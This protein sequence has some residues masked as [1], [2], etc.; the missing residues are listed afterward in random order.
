[1]RSR[2]G[3]DQQRVL[4][5]AGKLRPLTFFFRLWLFFRLHVAFFGQSGPD[6]AKVGHCHALQALLRLRELLIYER[7]SILAVLA[8]PATRLRT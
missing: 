7:V 4:L 2:T 1:M 8:M 5:F 3:H 6:R